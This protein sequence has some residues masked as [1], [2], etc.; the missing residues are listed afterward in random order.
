VTE[1]LLISV[2]EA[3]TRL[4]IGRDL[5]YKLVAEGRLRSLSLGRRVLVPVVELERFVASE[6]DSEARR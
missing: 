2:R 1:P 3:A 6:T 4:G 5:A